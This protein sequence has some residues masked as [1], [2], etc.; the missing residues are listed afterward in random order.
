MPK[1]LASR[2]ME[3]R[4]IEQLITAGTFGPLQGFRSRQGFPFAAVIKLDAEKKL[5]FDFGDEKKEDGSSAEVDFTG[6]E[7]VGQ[8]PKC[9]G[10][11]F[12]NGMNYVCERSVGAAKSCDF[13]TGSVI[14][15]QS[16]DRTQAA[17]LLTQGKTDLL[18]DFVS[19]KTGRKF[20]AFLTLKEGKV[21][22][23]FAPREKKFPAKGKKAAEPEAKID[24][25]GLTSVGACPKCKGKVYEGP[26]SWVCERTQADTR[27]CTFK[28]GRK[29]LEQPVE[30][31][32]VE[33]LLQDGRT[34]ALS[35]FVSKAGKNFTAHLVLGQ[36]GK[37]EFE[38]P[39]R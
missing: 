8:C 1:F 5:V 26:T 36:R 17:K 2:L 32:Q 20:E 39:D 15:Q 16:I 27:K 38:F 31:P 7:P 4:E 10:K 37:V 6:K 35:G 34:E 28:V 30:R 21:S 24:F 22:F 14:L 29:I 3:G 12:E 18:K 13:R 25:T 23:E 11:V 19:K 33:K 9:P